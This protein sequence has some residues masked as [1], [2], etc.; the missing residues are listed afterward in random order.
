MRRVR[1]PPHEASRFGLGA[2]RIVPALDQRMTRNAVGGTLWHLVDFSTPRGMTMKTVISG[3]VV[4]AGVFLSGCSSYRFQGH[5]AKGAST[6]VPCVMKYWIG[7]VVVR[8]DRQGEVGRWDGQ[9]INER[10]IR[11]DAMKRNPNLFAC[12]GEGIPLSVTIR[13]YS[14]RED[15]KY[16]VGPYS[17]TLGMCPMRIGGSSRCELTVA[18]EGERGISQTCD[19]QFQSDLKMSAMSPLGL[20]PFNRVPEAASYRRGSGLL[21]APLIDKGC[22]EDWEAVFVETLVDGIDVCVRE[23]EKRTPPDVLA[24][25]ANVPR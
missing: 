4:M 21:T 14:K 16:S 11:R 9:N 25:L 1:W 20:V 5:V 18:I 22:G 2:G 17:M 3:L 24:R 6:S 19:F 8:V 12:F 23:I 10:R 15:E 13:V 7:P